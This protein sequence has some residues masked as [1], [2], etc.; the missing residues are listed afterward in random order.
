M[1]GFLVGFICGAA[2][3]ALAIFIWFSAYDLR[4]KAKRRRGSL[5][6]KP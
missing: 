5:G 2:T 3:L 6:G 4:K 1:S